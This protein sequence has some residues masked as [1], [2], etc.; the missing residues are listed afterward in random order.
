[1]VTVRILG[2]LGNQLFQYAFGR[3]LALKKTTDLC[4][5]YYDQIIRTDF[6]GEN[7]TKI[8]DVFDLPVKLSIGKT[9]KDLVN[10]Y[11]LAF[12][13]RL[14]KSIYLKKTC[15]VTEENFGHSQENIE[16]NKN[17][18]LIGYWQSE[19]YFSDIKEIIKKEYKFKIDEKVK[20]LD[21]YNKITNNTSVSLHIRGKDYLK[22]PVYSQCDIKYYTDALNIIRRTSPDLKIFIFTDDIENTYQNYRELLV[23]SEIV[24]APSN[25]N[26]DAFD[27][28]L[29]S[30]CKH[31]VICNSSFSW[32]GAWLN[33]NP[34]KIII[35]PQ[36][37]FI[38]AD[39]SSEKLIPKDWVKI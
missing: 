24:R 32:W 4:L 6:D 13:D 23:A 8:T 31:N 37:W 1:M 39:Y 10:R 22:N 36:K 27:L 25:F 33:N 21:I 29:M 12:W 9:R 35:T 38:H 20:S 30:K 19:E 26:P 11:H 2:G 15:V 34:E 18:Y 16:K 3:S 17:I 7:L 14:I 28:L 5:D